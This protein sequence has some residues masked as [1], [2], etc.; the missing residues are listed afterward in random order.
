MANVQQGELGMQNGGGTPLGVSPRP[1]PQSHAQHQ[2][3]GGA[4]HAVNGQPQ[5]A[6][7]GANQPRGPMNS[8]PSRPT[9]L[10][11]QTAIEMVKR[12]REE[13]KSKS[14][15]RITLPAY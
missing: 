7:L 8:M 3:P 10:Q 12:L 14:L 1:R 2:I 13:N 6:Q 11:T 5:Q 4:Q 15:R 9:A